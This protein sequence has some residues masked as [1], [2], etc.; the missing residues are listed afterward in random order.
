MNF[1][2]IEQ[3]ILLK[4]VLTDSLL[5]FFFKEKNVQGLFGRWKD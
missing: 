1:V 4:L 3:R 2:K 5:P